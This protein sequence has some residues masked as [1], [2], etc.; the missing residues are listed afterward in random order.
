MACSGLADGIGPGLGH[1][2][3]KRKPR[4]QLAASLNN[5]ACQPAA[6]AADTFAGWSSEDQLPRR[7]AKAP[8][9]MH[10]RQDQTGA[11]PDV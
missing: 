5:S 8:R 2:P 9:R 11:L 7:H 4:S 3:I 6:R 10:S 1:H